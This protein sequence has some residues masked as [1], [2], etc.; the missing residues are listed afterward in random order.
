MTEEVTMIYKHITKRINTHKQAQAKAE[1]T[2]D[3]IQSD[4]HDNILVE[5]YAIRRFIKGNCEL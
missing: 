4:I 5:L 1:E 3:V 2:E